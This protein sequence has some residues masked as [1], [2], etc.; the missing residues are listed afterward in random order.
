MQ[1]DLAVDIVSDR[2]MK[3]QIDPATDL[4]EGIQ[5]QSREWAIPRCQ[6]R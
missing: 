4:A 5:I 1:T 3:A 6:A 2:L